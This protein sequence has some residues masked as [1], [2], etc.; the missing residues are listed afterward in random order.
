MSDPTPRPGEIWLTA[1][2]NGSQDTTE[3]RATGWHWPVSGARCSIHNRKPIRRI[4]FTAP[5]A[6]RKPQDVLRE[7]AEIIDAL[8][9]RPANTTPVLVDT[10]HGPSRWYALRAAADHLEREHAETTKRDRLIEHAA[11]VMLG[12]DSWAEITPAAREDALWE[13]AALYDAGMLR[14]AVTGDE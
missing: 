1:L 11:R 9:R 13:A 3:Y 14:E 6:D 7:A 4:G 2:P 12:D 8:D 5:P 10:S